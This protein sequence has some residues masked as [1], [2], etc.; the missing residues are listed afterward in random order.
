MSYV[1]ISFIHGE[2]VFVIWLKY[3]KFLCGTDSNQSGAVW[4]NHFGSIP[5][6]I[7]PFWDLWT[8]QKPFWGRFW[9]SLTLPANSVKSLWPQM[10]CTGVPHI[11]L[12]ILCWTRTYWG[13]FRPSIYISLKSVLALFQL[14][15]GEVV[16]V[17]LAVRILE[18]LLLGQFLQIFVWSVSYAS[19]SAAQRPKI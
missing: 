12:H 9:P 6:V 13:H 8:A 15:Q 3:S 5:G 2:V 10:S 11:V 14:P 4:G 7:D 19:I 1:K 18:I 16:F 17:A